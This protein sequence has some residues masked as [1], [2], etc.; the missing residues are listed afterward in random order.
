MSL[1]RHAWY[2]FF[3]NARTAALRMSARLSSTAAARSDTWRSLI[4]LRCGEHASE[5]IGGTNVKP[6][7]HAATRGRRGWRCSRTW[8]RRACGFESVGDRAAQ[9]VLRGAAE[10]AAGLQHVRLRERAERVQP[11]LAVR[12]GLLPGLA[13]ALIEVGGAEVSPPPG[14]VSGQGRGGPPPR[15]PGPR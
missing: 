15:E 9:P 13:A 11:E 1:T 5:T 6:N 12:R 7:R 2:P 8:R 4:A 3:A 14:G 10:L